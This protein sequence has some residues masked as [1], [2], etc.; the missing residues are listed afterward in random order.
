MLAVAREDLVQGGD[1]GARAD[2][3]RL[4]PEGGRPQAELALALQRGRLGVEATPEHH[5]PQVGG[6]DVVA[7]TEREDVVGDPLPVGGQQLDE[8]AATLNAGTAR[9][10]DVRGLGLWC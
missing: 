7:V 2:L 10:D 8:L 5:V 1:G 3:G 4:L 6:D 9:G